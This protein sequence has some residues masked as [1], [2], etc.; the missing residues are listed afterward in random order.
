MG[1]EIADLHRIAV[2]IIDALHPGVPGTGQHAFA[3]Q[4]KVLLSGGHFCLFPG[5]HHPVVSVF[6]HHRG[7]VFVKIAFLS[8]VAVLRIGTAQGRIS[9]R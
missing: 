2:F 1:S 4:A 6:L 8:D 3:I 9:A 7:T 5:A